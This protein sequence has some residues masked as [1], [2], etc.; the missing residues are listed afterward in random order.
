[1]PC[2]SQCWGGFIQWLRDG[3]FAGLEKENEE[4]G[5]LR[6]PEVECVD[7]CCQLRLLPAP[8]FTL[9]LVGVLRDAAN[10]RA[11]AIGDANN[12]SV[13]GYVIL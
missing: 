4:H 11:L 6:A 12:C 9:I 5:N 8:S 3:C 7:R 2:S 1:M 13:K 10:S